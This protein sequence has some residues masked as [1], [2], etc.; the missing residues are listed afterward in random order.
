MW[1]VEHRINFNCPPLVLHMLERTSNDEPGENC[2]H[3]GLVIYGR[4]TVLSQPMFYRIWSGTEFRAHNRW[5][6]GVWGC[7]GKRICMQRLANLYLFETNL[8]SMSFPFNSF[9]GL[10]VQHTKWA[11]SSPR[12]L[13][14]V[15]SVFASQDLRPRS[16]PELHAAHITA[17]RWSCRIYSTQQV[18]RW[19]HLSLA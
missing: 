6:S 4:E 9:S 13:A 17:L 1:N 19:G 5:L 11:W 12:K 18:I 14:T 7:A 16:P 10:Q 3:L 8:L 15:C 2:V